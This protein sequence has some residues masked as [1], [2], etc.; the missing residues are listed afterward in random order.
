MTY[1]ATPQDVERAAD[2]WTDDQITCRVYGHNWQPWT[3]RH[4]PGLF[5]ILQRCGRCGNGRQQEIND[6]GYP[7]SGW[8]P[9]YQEGYLLKGVGRLGI[10]GRA[11]LRLATLRVLYVE[12]VQV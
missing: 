4:S 2:G 3:I 6:R 10:D 1:W 12:E 8:R 9:S 5:T 7:V 11:V